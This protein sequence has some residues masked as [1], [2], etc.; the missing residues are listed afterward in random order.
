MKKILVPIDGSKSSS[1]AIEKAKEIALAFNSQV[2]LL[3]VM[4]SNINDYPSNPYKFSPEL[5]NNMKKENK[6]ISEKILEDGKARF[7]GLP[8][9]VETKLLEGNPAEMITQ[10]AMN[11]DYDLVIMGSSGMSGLRTI[12]VGSVTR[13]VT[14]NLKKPI[15]IVR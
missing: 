8:I 7:I 5:V 14:M 10:C 2:I 11:D 9:K 1:M 6:G 15:L 3:T 12:L 4:E 13:S